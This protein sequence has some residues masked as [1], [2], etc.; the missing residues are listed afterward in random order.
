MYNRKTPLF[1]GLCTELRQ[2]HQL[3]KS[4]Y[5]KFGSECVQGI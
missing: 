4:P 5:G 2:T 3:R 1:S